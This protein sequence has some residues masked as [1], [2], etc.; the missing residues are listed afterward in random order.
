MDLNSH[1]GRCCG[2]RHFHTFNGR[3]TEGIIREYLRVLAPGVLVEAVITD[4]Q[5]NSAILQQ[6]LI[7]SGF[8]RVSHF[9]NGNTGNRC[10]IYHYHRDLTVVNETTTPSKP[11]LWARFKSFFK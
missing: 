9:I 4:T 11:T 8:R 2:I 3:E 6:R 5:R 7:N 10:N 1:G